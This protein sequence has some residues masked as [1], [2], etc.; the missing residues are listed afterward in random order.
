M[1]ADEYPKVY[2]YR[3]IVHAKLFIDSHYAGAIDLDNIAG[4][5]T[6]KA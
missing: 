1:T 2:L 6:G 4:E 3:R 5:A